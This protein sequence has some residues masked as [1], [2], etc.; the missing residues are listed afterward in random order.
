[1]RKIL[2]PGPVI[3]RQLVGGRPAVAVVAAVQPGIEVVHVRYL[4]RPSG[5]TGLSDHKR[6]G[7]VVERSGGCPLAVACGIHHFASFRNA[8]TESESSLRAEAAGDE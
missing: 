8:A 3:D 6:S 5:T 4:Q 1:H 2:P 7:T